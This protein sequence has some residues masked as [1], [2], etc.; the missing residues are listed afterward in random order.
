MLAVQIL[1]AFIVIGGALW[2][3]SFLL[4]PGLCALAFSKAHEAGW[5]K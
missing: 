4:I 3:F 1:G 5:F 2:T